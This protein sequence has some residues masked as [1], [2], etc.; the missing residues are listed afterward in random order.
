MVKNIIISL[1]FLLFFLSSCSNRYYEETV[2]KVS[3]DGIKI[4]LEKDSTLYFEVSKEEKLIFEKKPTKDEIK[5]VEELFEGN[6]TFKPQHFIKKETILQ[7]IDLVFEKK[8]KRSVIKNFIILDPRFSSGILR[9]LGLILLRGR[10][11]LSTNFILIPLFKVGIYNPDWLFFN[12]KEE[13]F[14]KLNDELL[15]FVEVT[16]PIIPLN[17]SKNKNR[18]LSISPNGNFIAILEEDNKI[19]VINLRDKKAVYSEGDVNNSFFEPEDKGIYFSKNDGLYYI[20][21]FTMN[22]QKILN[23]SYRDLIV[24]PSGKHILI[25]RIG[26]IEPFLIQIE[27]NKSLKYIPLNEKL[28]NKKEICF[29]RE[30]EICAFDKEKITFFNL[31]TSSLK[32]TKIDGEAHL[33]SIGK[34]VSINIKKNGRSENL[35]SFSSDDVNYH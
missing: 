17:Y 31:T 23:G 34:F 6:L 18:K 9:D 3:T 26:E 2:S 13:K 15:D 16:P 29:F 8:D 19:K 32:E 33:I 5:L 14:F 30:K 25:Y 21:L 22:R 35:S 24:S 4:S 10:E 27:N 12:F 1:P 28:I 20:D 11:N 7:R